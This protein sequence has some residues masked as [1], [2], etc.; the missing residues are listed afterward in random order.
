M[1]CKAMDKALRR[2]ILDTRNI[3]QQ[4]EKADCN[5]SET[6]R[7]IE[8][9]FEN[10]MGYDVFKHLSRERAIRGAGET[11]HVDFSIQIEES[12]DAK[13]EIMVEIKRVS[14][15]LAPKHLKQVSSY[16]INAGCEWILLTNSREWRIYHVAFGQPPITKLVASWNVLTD[17]I[18]VLAD[19][20][21][22][23]SFKSVR[24]GALAKLWQ[25]TNVLHPRN[26]LEAILS[27]GAVKNI[28]KELKKDSGITLTPE[29][30]VSGIRRLLNESALTELEGIRISFPEKKPKQR[31]PKPPADVATPIETEKT[32]QPEDRQLSSES[33]PSASPEE[34][35]SCR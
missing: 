8:R 31:K 30:I 28:R 20:F 29:D 12:Q 24:K 5:E 9:I 27:E 7:S 16:A 19:R 25:K 2:E 21:E 35:S 15:D 1:A 3:I 13:P 23:I 18:A 22:L 4:A 34:V 17:D 33:A 10:L 26:L 6:R 32:V 11:E 14:V